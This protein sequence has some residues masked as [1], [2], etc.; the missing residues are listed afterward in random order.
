[1]KKVEKQIVEKPSTISVFYSMT[2]CPRWVNL[3][4]GNN[5]PYQSFLSKLNS[6]NFLKERRERTTIKQ[7]ADAFHFKREQLTK[8]ISEM[9]ED[10]FDLNYDNPELF[11]DEGI[12]HELYFK[13]FRTSAS[14]TL[15]L[16]CTPR[17][18]EKVDFFFLKAKLESTSFWVKDLQ[19]QFDESEHTINVWLESSI[20]N[21]YRELLIDRALFFDRL[22]FMDV[23]R[24]NEFEIDDKLKLFY[25][26]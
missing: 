9:Y 23:Y 1:M 12:K 15:W 21:K 25:K 5:K 13:G 24:K 26:H 3:L 17:V 22:G 11:K 4:T 20:R 10:I 2:S 8:W 6:V 16:K 7:M 18:F 14:F 19:H